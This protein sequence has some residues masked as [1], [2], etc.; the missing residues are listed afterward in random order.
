MSID[1]L[2]LGSKIHFL[3]RDV[4]HCEIFKQSVELMDT[5]VDIQNV[6][7]AIIMFSLNM[8]HVLFGSLSI[9]KIHLSFKLYDSS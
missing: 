2:S 3:L 9:F 4:C 8:W 5:Y 6:S 1:Q 7:V